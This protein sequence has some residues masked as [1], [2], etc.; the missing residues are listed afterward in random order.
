MLPA[1]VS[2]DVKD[3]KEKGNVS[4][5]V[6]GRSCLALDRKPKWPRSGMDSLTRSWSCIGN[7]K[8]RKQLSLEE[9]C[10]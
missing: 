1:A 2:V 7:A 8:H 9:M 5:K 6:D 4:V 10:P 3:S